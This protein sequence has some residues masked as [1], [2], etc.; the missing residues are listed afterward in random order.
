MVEVKR[1]RKERSDKKKDIKPTVPITLKE[2]VHRISYITNKP[3]KDVAEE[4]C[5]LGFEN[6]PI[7]E[8][9]SK[10]LRRDF[11]YKNTIFIGNIE[12]TSLQRERINGASDR[13]TIRFKQTDYDNICNLAYA[14]DVTPSKATA[15]LLECSVKSSNIIN[16]Y[17]KSYL[18]E[19]LDQARMRE[20]KKIIKYINQNNPDE[21]FS[22]SEFLS[23]IVDEIKT[24]TSNITNTLKIWIDRHK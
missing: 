8:K 9:L 18:K 15:L 7:I 2:T 24:E 5:L 23:F 17:I 12:R 22:W 20:L 3:V 11:K 1:T 14:L 19:H 6:R 13:I 16:K 21:E 4:I 10:H